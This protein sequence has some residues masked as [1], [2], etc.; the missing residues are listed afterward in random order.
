M[1]GN[2]GPNMSK[3]LAI[4]RRGPI[5][6][7]RRQGILS[8]ILLGLGAFIFFFLE[9]GTG[10]LSGGQLVSYISN[11]QF[12]F[13]SVLEFLLIAAI[14]IIAYA[15]YRTTTNW[16]WLAVALIMA[17]GNTIA[18]L[19]NCSEIV[20][21]D[22]VIYTFGA[23]EKARFIILGILNAGFFFVAFSVV[24][25]IITT[26]FWIRLLY[27]VI[28]ALALISML[29]SFLD[30]FDLWKTFFET[31]K[32]SGS[33]GSF[34]HNK[35]IFA[36]VIFFGFCAEA[37]L[38][39]RTPRW[40]RWIL[41]LF[42]AVCQVPLVSRTQS[43]LT[44]AMVIIVPI[45]C[46]A[47]SLSAHKIRNNV[48]LGLI[49]AGIVGVI[50]FLSLPTRE[51]NSILLTLMADFFHSIITTGGNTLTARVEIAERIFN[52]VNS[53]GPLGTAFGL[54]FKSSLYCYCGW[55]N[56]GVHASTPVDGEYIYSFLAGGWV[57]AVLEFVVWIAVLIVILRAMNKG[58]K[59]GAVSLTLWCIFGIRSF[60]EMSGL[61]YFESFSMGV[62]AV[63]ALTPLCY[64]F[65]HDHKELNQTIAASL[66]TPVREKQVRINPPFTSLRR[67]LC[68]SS[69][70]V[71]IALMAISVQKEPL[72]A[73]NLSSIFGIIVFGF[74]GT[75]LFT[76]F[77]YKKERIAGKILSSI[78]GLLVFFL[79]FFGSLFIPAPLNALL[80]IAIAVIFLA[81][82]SYM[83]LMP[84]LLDYIA[85]YFPFVAVVSLS[86]IFAEVGLLYL[87]ADGFFWLTSLGTLMALWTIVYLLS[88]VR[89]FNS[90]F[91]RTL[92]SLED[93][94]DR[95]TVVNEAKMEDL[96]FRKVIRKNTLPFRRKR[97]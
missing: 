72:S 21:K 66:A 95:W 59:E 32:L 39:A 30:E 54:G 12:L 74:L 76:T 50:I 46:Y 89:L 52:F 25:R 84:N 43:L 94:F 93:S 92:L 64:N 23:I 56:G 36:T 61:L 44:L 13:L 67:V 91:D 15:G 97:S 19:F 71:S 57:G 14:L 33:F 3:R 27:R 22:T 1:G 42:L 6:P 65:L 87:E 85:L 83:R 4:F 88:P 5:V 70:A 20:Y 68:L 8:G 69:I 45:L 75:A 18:V 31:W 51:G 16:G 47:R 40:W 82:L 77:D 48:A 17:V 24:P 80:V 38:L 10:L 78:G 37:L 86:L 28:V 73:A 81:V 63:V 35:N 60:V 55:M 26:S 34:Y 9:E 49:L 29:F 11:E 62:Y 2:V 90:G 53:S 79:G 96:Y 58:L 7:R 41:F